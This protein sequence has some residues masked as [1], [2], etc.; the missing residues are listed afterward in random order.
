LKVYVK[1]RPEQPGNI[2]NHSFAGGALGVLVL[3]KMIQSQTRSTTLRSEPPQIFFVAFL[4]F[5][6][7]K[8][9]LLC[10]LIIFVW[11]WVF[12][13]LG[14]LEHVREVAHAHGYLFSFW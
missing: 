13:Y 7:I 5:I 2:N 8:C 11:A 1:L 6:V 12:F 10:L 14:R 3:I 4:A 9:L